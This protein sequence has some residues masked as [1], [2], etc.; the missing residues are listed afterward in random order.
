M[1]TT[2]FQEVAFSRLDRFHAYIKFHKAATSAATS[3]SFLAV[4]NAMLD[5]TIAFGRLGDWVALSQLQKLTGLSRPAVKEG[6]ARAIKAG[7]L[8]QRILGPVNRKKRIILLSVPENLKL[9]E[10]FDS[11]KISEEDFMASASQL[12]WG[13]TFYPPISNNEIDIISPGSEER[14]FTPKNTQEE[15]LLP[16]ADENSAKN[17]GLKIEGKK[18][19]PQDLD[20]RYKDLRS[21]KIPD[22]QNLVNP[23]SEKIQEHSKTAFKIPDY[24]P[25]QL[26]EQISQGLHSPNRIVRKAAEAMLKAQRPEMRVHHEQTIEIQKSWNKNEKA[27]FD[28]AREEKSKEIARLSVPA[29]ER[30]Q[31]LFD[32]YISPNCNEEDPLEKHGSML[33]RFKTLWDNSDTNVRFLI[34]KAFVD[35]KNNAYT[36]VPVIMNFKKNIRKAGLEIQ[37]V[38]ANGKVS[39]HGIV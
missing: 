22:H 18:V 7:V 37:S 4:C 26:R 12:Y 16:P 5:K 38:L 21:E 3:H 14:S 1:T 32:V 33:K 34:E 10:L 24:V 27:K 11:E 29:D 39:A 28:V 13:Q 20:L 17:E 31:H 36:F 2:L 9:V 8:I 35:T 19:S 30:V 15:R 6:L 23:I 25:E